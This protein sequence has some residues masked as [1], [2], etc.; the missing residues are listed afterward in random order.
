MPQLIRGTITDV[1]WT[2]TKTDAGIEDKWQIQMPQD[3]AAVYS[4]IFSQV[5][6]PILQKRLITLS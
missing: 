3:V 4:E 1:S 2:A 6:N 5:Q